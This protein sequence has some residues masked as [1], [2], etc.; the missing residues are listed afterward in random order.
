MGWLIDVYPDGREL[1]HGTGRPWP[2]PEFLDRPEGVPDL[3]L[4][5]THYD[6]EVKA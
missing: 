4:R 2:V 1:E 6:N 5:L 3:V